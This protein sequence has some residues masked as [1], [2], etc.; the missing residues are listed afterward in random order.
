MQYQSQDVHMT[1]VFV[2]LM[3]IYTKSLLGDHLQQGSTN[4]G[5]GHKTQ[6]HVWF[7][8]SVVNPFHGQK[9][10]GLGVNSVYSKCGK[11]DI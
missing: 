9:W 8:G 5:S 11:R 7:R 3:F 4:F 1:I 6:T 10:I 2:I